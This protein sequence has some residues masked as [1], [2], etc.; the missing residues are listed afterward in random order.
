MEFSSMAMARK[1]PKEA[2][3]ER[4]EKDSHFLQLSA[5]QRHAHVS[6]IAFGLPV[7]FSGGQPDQS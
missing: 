3:K 1:G 5:H 6:R 4:P 2:R 7:Q